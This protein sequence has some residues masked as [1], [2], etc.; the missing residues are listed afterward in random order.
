[1]WKNYAQQTT[2]DIDRK[3]IIMLISLQTFF[4]AARVNIFCVQARNETFTLNFQPHQ[5]YTLRGLHKLCVCVC[6]RAFL[7][8]N[9]WMPYMFYRCFYNIR[10][11]F[12]TKPSLSLCVCLC[13]MRELVMPSDENEAGKKCQCFQ[14][15][16]NGVFSSPRHS[17][18]ANRDENKGKS[19][20]ALNNRTLFSLLLSVHFRAIRFD[21]MR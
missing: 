11:A 16:K 20:V 13:Q 10:S 19:I 8:V 14:A 2:I 5:R 7:G 9:Y 12:V 18:H 15:K 21:S 4:A 6:V 1:M 3:S 17:F